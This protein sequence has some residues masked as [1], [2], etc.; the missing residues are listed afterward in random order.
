MRSVPR[1]LARLVHQHFT[2]SLTDSDEKLVNRHGGVDGDFTTEQ[3]LNVVLLY[4][5]RLGVTS[6]NV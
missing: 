5:M 4:V 2:V 3:V 6:E 1:R